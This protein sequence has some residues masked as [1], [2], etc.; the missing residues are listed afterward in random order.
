MRYHIVI[1]SQKCCILYPQN[2]LI[3]GSLYL[4]IPFTHF[5]PSPPPPVTANLFSVSMSLLLLDSTYKW[6]PTI[7]VFLWFISISAFKI[8]LTNP[9]IQ[10]ALS[11]SL[12]NAHNIYLGELN[13]TVNS[14]GMLTVWNTPNF[15]LMC[16]LLIV[17]PHLNT[18]PKGSRD[19][20]S[21]SAVKNACGGGLYVTWKN[22]QGWMDQTGKMELTSD[23]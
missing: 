15:V 5:A 1:F 12:M 23:S 6:Y 22:Q 4:W 7:Y 19:I 8:F 18:A 14:Y 11:V 9:F 16:N 2:L 13:Q 21:S 20:K 17:R 10:K 3:T